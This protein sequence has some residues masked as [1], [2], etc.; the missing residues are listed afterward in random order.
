MDMC[1]EICYLARTEVAGM[2]ADTTG[3]IALDEM[4]SLT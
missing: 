2:L 1:Q 3:T 4:L